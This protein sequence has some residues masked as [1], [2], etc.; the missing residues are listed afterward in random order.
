MPSRTSPARQALTGLIVAVAI[1]ATLMWGLALALSERGQPVAN[2]QP[3]PTGYL[4][5]S[6]LPPFRGTADDPTRDTTSAPVLIE[7]TVII[8]PTSV[9]ATGVTATGVGASPTP[10]AA[11]AGSCQISPVWQLYRIQPG[12][13]LFLIGLRYGLTVDG[14]MRGNCLN[15]TGID[16]GGSLYVPPVTPFA[17]GTSQFILTATWNPVQPSAAPVATGTQTATDGS[18][19][20]PDST[21]LSPRVGQIITGAVP[22]VGAARVPN[23]AFYKIEIRQ[24]GAPMAY[25][26]LF[27]GDHE[28]ARGTLALLDTA[29]WP[30]GEYWLRLVVVDAT[31]NYPERCALLVIFSNW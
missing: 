15:D 3:T 16:A 12:D 17:V 6:R 2:R 25:A 27:T 8:I 29:I 14:I 26:N 19:A 21:I 11:V 30:N 1:I 9:P 13:T 5:P 10:T 7:P 18:C 23:F 31:G 22:I 28:V 4:I 20:N 24:E